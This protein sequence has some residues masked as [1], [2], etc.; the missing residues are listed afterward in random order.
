MC[1][2]QSRARDSLLLHI[3]CCPPAPAGYT[4]SLYFVLILVTTVGWGDIVPYTN[5]EASWLPAALR[6]CYST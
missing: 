6:P 1:S 3:P 5:T 4:F 2:M